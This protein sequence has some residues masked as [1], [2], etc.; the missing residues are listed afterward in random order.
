MATKKKEL[1]QFYVN[2][3]LVLDTCILINAESLDDALAKSKNLEISDYVDIIGDNNDNV[4]GITG[5]FEL[6]SSPEL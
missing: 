1:R 4:F 6:T 2:A 5:I 3:R